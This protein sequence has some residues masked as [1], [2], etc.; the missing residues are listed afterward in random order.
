MSV[1]DEANTYSEKLNF[2]KAKRLGKGSKWNYFLNVYKTLNCHEFSSCGCTE[3]MKILRFVNQ[4]KI[5]FF[6]NLDCLRAYCSNIYFA[7]QGKKQKN[8]R[9][10]ERFCPRP[11]VQFANIVIH[12]FQLDQ[13]QKISCCLFNFAQIHI[14]IPSWA[15]VNTLMEFC[16]VL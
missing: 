9:V 5:P 10:S 15:K 6:Y 2:T 13:H 4:Q 3:C 14:P 12:H 11:N 1:K 16:K 8:L 7:T